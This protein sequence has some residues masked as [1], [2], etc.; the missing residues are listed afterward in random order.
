ME[1]QIIELIKEGDIERLEDKY[2]EPARI[3]RLT[4]HLSTLKSLGVMV[5]SE[6]NWARDNI[7]VALLVLMKQ[8]Q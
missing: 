2:S 8:R 1:N 5:P 4:R 3:N 6:T 7:R